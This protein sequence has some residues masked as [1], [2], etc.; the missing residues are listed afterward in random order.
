M[1][2]LKKFASWGYNLISSASKVYYKAFEDN[3]VA[4]EIAC[5]SKMHP[6][7]KAINVVYHLFCEH[8]CLGKI[9]IYPNIT[10][11]QLADVFPKPLAQNL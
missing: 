5:L 3:S 7:M 10:S 9:F 4:L 2:L 1:K 6:H 8:V 11:S